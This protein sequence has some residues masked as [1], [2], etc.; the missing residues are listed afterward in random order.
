MAGV[1]GVRNATSALEV[2]DQAR[3]LVAGYMWHGLDNLAMPIVAAEREL[4]DPETSQ[5]RAIRLPKKT[6]GAR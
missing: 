4:D 1:A 3:D 2:P 5:C 6:L